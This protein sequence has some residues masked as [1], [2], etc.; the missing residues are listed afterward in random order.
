MTRI[1]ALDPGSESFGWSI[2]EVNGR[3]MP[4]VIST[5]MLSRRIKILTGE[6]VER[7]VNLFTKRFRSLVKI[8]K[9]EYVIIERYTPRRF[10]LSNE[11]I[12]Y[13]IGYI[14]CELA[15]T[16]TPVELV[17]P[18]TWKG[19]VKKFMDLDAFYTMIDRIAD[20]MI[21][22][23]F[24]GLFLAEKSFSFDM[25]ALARPTMRVRLAK[26]IDTVCQT[27]D[28]KPPKR[29]AKKNVVAKKAT[30]TANRKAK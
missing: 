29:V 19:R 9:P 16:G 22:A 5:G 1:L 28:R 6:N 12:N 15:I 26:M 10:G 30:T 21:D 4:K 18:A 7:E 25:S 8:A 3:A 2:L 20:H 17:M 23:T 24:M 14:R 11:S 27:K 13:M